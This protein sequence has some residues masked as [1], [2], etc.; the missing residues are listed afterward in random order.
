MINE[1]VSLADVFDDS[2][3]TGPS[4]M[5]VLTESASSSS[6]TLKLERFKPKLPYGELIDKLVKI[7][8]VESPMCK[9]EH[10]YKCCT[11]E[12]QQTLDK[13]WENYNIPSKKLS[14]DVD[15]LQS[16]IVYFISRMKSCP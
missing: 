15:N 16:M 9:L 4:K 14:V 13:F 5:I 8:S 2:S 11:I 7:D 6:N 12:I 1:P 3:N 10:I